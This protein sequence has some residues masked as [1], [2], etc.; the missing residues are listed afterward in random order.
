MILYECILYFVSNQFFI[1]RRLQNNDFAIL[2]KKI[3]QLFSN[4]C[5][6]T[7]YVPPKL[8][9]HSRVNKPERAKGKLVDKYRN[10]LTFI[11]KADNLVQSHA[12]VKKSNKAV[13]L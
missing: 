12:C 10:K 2:T 9:K 11:R 3:M 1:Y 6:Q 8:K 13:V 4:E 5:Y 7:Y